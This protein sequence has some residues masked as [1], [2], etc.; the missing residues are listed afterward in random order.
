MI[1]AVSPTT[2]LAG[3]GLWL[4]TWKSQVRWRRLPILAL[5]VGFL[6]GLAYFTISNGRSEIFF[7]W[8]IDFY[9]T[10]LL[11][12]YSLSICGAMIRDELQADTIGFLLT[13]PI[14]RARLFLLKFICHVTWVQIL[15]CTVTVLLLLVGVVREIQELR[16]FALIFLGTQVLAV[17][18]YGALGALIGLINQRYMVL[19]IIYGFV[20]EVGIG[21][22]P[23]NI[24][25][26]SQLRHLHTILANVEAL[27]LF[28]PWSSDRTWLSVAI[29]LIA[30]LIFLAAGAYLFTVREYHAT[31]EMRK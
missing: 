18:V 20:V 22:I 6:P 27:Q 21:Q 23:T 4:L 15:G 24:N 31:D 8:A 10:L 13:R 5:M 12:L 29:L 16:S 14:S 28:Y 17:F 9:L 2:L 1:K 26:L 25:N 3:R 30:P 19:G 11:P 7:K